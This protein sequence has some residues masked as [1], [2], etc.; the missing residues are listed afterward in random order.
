VTFDGFGDNSLNLILRCYLESLDYR[1]SVAS[2]L[3]QAVNDKFAAANISIAFPQRDVHLDTSGPLE[4]RISGSDSHSTGGTPVGP[5]P[6]P[7]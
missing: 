4:V 1:L 5:I 3:R 7:S 2:E 6:K